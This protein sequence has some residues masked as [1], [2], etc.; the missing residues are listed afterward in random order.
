MSLENMK[1]FANNLKSWANGSFVAKESGKGLSEANYTETEKTKLQG[2][3]AGAQ[4]N[5][6]E[7]IKV[8]GAAQAVSDK[9]IN[10]DLSVYALKS[11]MSSALDWKGTKASVSELPESGNKTGDMWHVADK[12]AEYVW[13]GTS[14]EGVGSIV[15][16]SEYYTKT[17]TN[18]AITNAVATKADK[19]TFES[20]IQRINDIITSL[21]IPEGV[22]VDKALS[23]TST[24]AIANKAVTAELNLKA[25]K[26]EVRDLST[27]L[28]TA[29]GKKVDQ[30]AYDTKIRAIEGT[31]STK[32]NSADVYTKGET[33]TQTQINSAI[34]TAAGTVDTRLTNE[35]ATLNPV[36]NGKADKS[37]VDTQLDLKVNS[38]DII[39]F[40]NDEID[41]ATA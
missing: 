27:S 24:N 5:V 3:A 35:L 2:I 10:I 32:A 25:T 6:I 36:V 7:T 29:I 30:T 38:A 8:N 18:T 17:E 34:E 4:V 12:S 16:L 13:N 28:T 41:S 9:A 23:T 39:A 40:T 31:I 1:R 33:Y 19:S 26:E 14:W 21:D 15:D 37:Y 11:D 20:E 22:V